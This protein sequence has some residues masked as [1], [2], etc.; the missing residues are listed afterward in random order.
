ME[1]MFSLFLPAS[2]LCFSLRFV[3]DYY[4]RVPAPSVF[5]DFIYAVC[6]KHFAFNNYLI[7]YI[8]EI[9]LTV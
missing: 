4:V 6:D 7:Y 3:P 8:L 9:A 5:L 1:V 2:S